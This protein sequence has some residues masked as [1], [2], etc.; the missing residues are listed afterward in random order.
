MS[1]KKVN[2]DKFMDLLREPVLP[3]VFNPWWQN[4]PQ[5]DDYSNSSEIRR[6]Q[7]K[8]YL[9]ERVGQCRFLLVGEALGYQGGHFTGVPMVSE[10]ILLGLHEA[11]GIVADHVFNSMVPTRTSRPDLREKGFNEPTATIVWQHLIGSGVV[12]KEFAIWN[13]FP[14]HPFVEA[15]GLLSNRTP[16][17]A[18][19]ELGLPALKVVIRITGAKTIVAVGE[20]A[21]ISLTKSGIEHSKVRHPAN[22][23]ATKFREQI[24]LIL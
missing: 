19:L 12:P 8:A 3:Q 5:H 22:G 6:H 11:K 4:D 15:K 2:L 13:A 17:D 1:E 18:E 9:R 24:S 20:K 14:W 10:R 7:L 23:G 16:T 21:S